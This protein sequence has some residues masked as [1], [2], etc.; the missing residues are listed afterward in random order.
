MDFHS[1]SVQ[2]KL[3]HLLLIC[4]KSA[5]WN[6]TVHYCEYSRFYIY[7]LFLFFTFYL[8]YNSALCCQTKLVLKESREFTDQPTPSGLCGTSK[9]VHLIVIG[10]LSICTTN[11]NRPVYHPLCQVFAWGLWIDSNCWWNV[12]QRHWWQGSLSSG[13]W[14]ESG[15]ILS[16]WQWPE[17]YYEKANLF[18]WQRQMWVNIQG[19]P[20]PP[21]PL[22]SSVCLHV[23][24][25][26]P[27][28]DNPC[29]PPGVRFVAMA[30]VPVQSCK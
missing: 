14:G 23:A 7:Y 19:A 16:S 20:A 22:S 21:L 2:K 1:N 12:G 17:L 6:I 26:S 13:P 25:L 11:F 8:S 15:L 4:Y 24:R 29:S 30:T 18:H 10:K 3:S 28:Q 5:S 27:S 9:P